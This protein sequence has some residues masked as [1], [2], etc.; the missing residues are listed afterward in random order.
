[1]SS[2][3]YP[4]SN[5]HAEAAMKSIKH[6]ILKT[7]PSGNINCE[8][9]DQDLLELR[10]TPNITGCS[11][12]QILYGHPLCTCVPA[13]PQSFSKEW[14]SKS[15]DCGHRAA[16]HAEHVKIQYDQHA[17]PLPRLNIG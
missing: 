12:A 2:P 7:A 4:Q 10:N 13:H 1:M 17:H 15:E 16:T 6:L 8:E 3:R 5:G 9:F 14:Q 11:P